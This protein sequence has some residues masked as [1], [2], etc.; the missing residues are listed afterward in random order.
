[1]ILDDIKTII[2]LTDTSK[3]N[4]LNIFIRKAATLIRT[5]LNCDDSVDITTAYPDAIIEFVMSELNRRGNEGVRQFSQGSRSG[6]YTNELS[7]NV[8]SLLPLPYAILV[9]TSGF[10]GVILP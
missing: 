4:I 10:N 6:T 5:Y 9:N 7:E 2:G 3:D 8:I 1:L